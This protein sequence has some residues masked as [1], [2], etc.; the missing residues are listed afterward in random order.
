MSDILF[1]SLVTSG[2]AAIIAALV[3]MASHIQNP[4]ICWLLYGGIALLMFAFIPKYLDEITLLFKILWTVWMLALTAPLSKAFKTMDRLSRPWP[5]SGPDYV[6][7]EPYFKDVWRSACAGKLY[8]YGFFVE[9]NRFIKIP[10]KKLE[11]SS[12]SGDFS[13]LLAGKYVIATNLRMSWLS[14]IV[15]G[16]K[17]RS[18]K[19]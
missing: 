5:L 13:M 12:I 18:H 4:I 1:G 3:A 6:K 15:H 7:L 14:A 10:I 17:L 9:E 16:L 19:R 8:V 11:M 2:S